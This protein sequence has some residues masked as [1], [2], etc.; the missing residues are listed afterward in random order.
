[1]GKKLLETNLGNWGE[2]AFVYNG[3]R[4]MD[5]QE[6]PEILSKECNPYITGNNEGVIVYLSKEEFE[7]IKQKTNIK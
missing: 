3:K 5:L 6:L 4:V 2:T 1:M 7:K